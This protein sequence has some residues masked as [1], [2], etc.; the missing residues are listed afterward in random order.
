MVSLSS[1][2]P[3]GVASLVTRSLSKLAPVKMAID[4]VDG[5]K[6]LIMI[7]IIIVILELQLLVRATLDKG[8]SCGASIG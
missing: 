8:H 3:D 5:L 7:I 4:Q 1:E 2:P 6:W